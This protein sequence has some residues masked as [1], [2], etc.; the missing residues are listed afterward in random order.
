MNRSVAVA[1]LSSVFVS[2]LCVAATTTGKR[3]QLATQS[4]E[5]ITTIA[6]TLTIV[7]WVG[8]VNE[9]LAQTPSAKTLGAKW[10]PQNPSWDKAFDEMLTGVMNRFDEL[11]DAPEA[12]QRLS[13]PFQSN[14]TEAEAAEVLALSAEERKQLDDYADTMTLAVNLMSHR[15]DLKIGSPEYQASLERLTHMAKLPTIK[16]VP[17][18][19][20]P[21]KTVDDYRHARMASVDFYE[22]AMR[23][24]L[25]LYFFDHREAMTKIA[26]KAARA[27]AAK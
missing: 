14:L 17:K 19:K 25:E 9:V 27:A 21:A 26:S 2:H 13:M 11:H 15:E 6:R 5:R 23:G 20:L 16:D 3:E 22:T 1:V 4:R 7:N 18:L 10:N 12:I 24:Q 8:R